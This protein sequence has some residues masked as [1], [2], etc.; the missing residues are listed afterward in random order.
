MTALFFSLVL[1]AGLDAGIEA[2][3]LRVEGDLVTTSSFSAKE[4][5]E[6]TP[7]PVEWT[8]KRGKHT[9]RGVRLDAV[10]LKAGFSEGPMGPTVE[11]KVKHQGLRAAVIATASD[12]YEAVFSMGELLA[13]LGA[14]TAWLV[15][16]V[17]G[18]P[19]S[20]E[21]GP[22]RLVIPT[23]KGASRSL[24]QLVKLRVVDLRGR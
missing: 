18:K 6:L 4:L 23:D 8:D 10:L 21:V 17:E 2:P 3:R 15:F 9:G 16:E 13:H 24:H 14:T 12:G 7:T 22:F 20:P 1:T 5:A 19:L 11:P